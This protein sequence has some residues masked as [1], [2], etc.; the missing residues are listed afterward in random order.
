MSPAILRALPVNELMLTL[1]ISEPQLSKRMAALLEASNQPGYLVASGKDVR[2]FY[3]AKCIYLGEDGQQSTLRLQGIH[4]R[5]AGN[6]LIPARALPAND[7]T[8]Y[9]QN[10]LFSFRVF[11][12]DLVASSKFHVPGFLPEFC[13]VAQALGAPFVENPELQVGIIELLKEQDQQ[14]RIDRGSGLNAMV[15]RAV[16]FHCHQGEQQQM[17][18]RE[19]AST[20]NRIYVEEGE[21][22]KISNETVGH[23]LKNLGLYTRRLGNMGRGLVLDKVTRLRAHELGQ[24]NQVLPETAGAPLCGHCHKLQLSQTEEVV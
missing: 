3:C 20:V 11:D 6:G 23:V 12:H 17:L 21:S 13:A 9:L 5:V 24:A 4:I 22:L 7:V 1:L 10:Q 2:Q 18:V 16:L 15:L 8:Q 19:I 14:A